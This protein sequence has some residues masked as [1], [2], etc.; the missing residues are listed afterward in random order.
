MSYLRKSQPTAI[1]VEIGTSSIKVVALQPGNP[2][3]LQ[4]AVMTPTPIGSMRDGAVVEPQAVANELKALLS[5][6]GITARHAV[7]AMPNQAAVTRNIMVPRMERKELDDAIRWE[8]ERYIPYPI[9]EVS[10][11]YDLL[12]DP[13]TVPEDGQMEVVIAAV[14]TEVVMRHIE[15]LRLAGLEPTVVDLKS[16][17]ALR[18]LLPGAGSEGN[19]KDAEVVLV[20]EIGASSSVIGLVRGNRLLM[21]RNVNVSADSFTIAIQ[22]SFGDLDFGTAES[23]KTGY[24]VPSGMGAVAEGGDLR[25]SP[26]RVSEALRPVLIEMITEVRRSLEFYRVQSGDL[27][28]DRVILAGGGAHLS[29]LAPAVGEALGLPVEVASPWANVQGNP[30][31]SAAEHGPEF[32]VPLGLAMRGVNYG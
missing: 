20:L 3:T 7:T 19:V 21:S 25:F 2:P 5:A 8:A 26:T 31:G 22:Q 9:D 13:K 4:Q 15:T 17:A 24:V 12:D 14:P 28:I 1:G 11:D 27:V 30:T 29:G 23:V 16:F 6:S 32:T 10:M 18:A